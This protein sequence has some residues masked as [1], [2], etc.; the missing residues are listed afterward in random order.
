MRIATGRNDVAHQD[1]AGFVQTISQA[2]DLVFAIFFLAVSLF[3]LARL[4]GQTELVKRTGT[5]AQPAFWPTVAVALMTGFAVPAPHRFS[6]VSAGRGALGGGE[7]LD[8]IRRIRALVHGLCLDGCPAARLGYLPSSI[9]FPA[10]LAFRLGYRAPRKLG[11][12]AASGVTVVVLFKS[13]LQVKVPGG[14]IYETLPD[15]MRAF[16]LTYF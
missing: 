4:G 7:I 16:M 11:F 1:I 9:V 14:A 3:L 13:L 12:A 10:L 8:S 5:V 6:G 2:G 15:A